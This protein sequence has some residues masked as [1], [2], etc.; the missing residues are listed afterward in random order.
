MSNICAVVIRRL[1]C[2]CRVFLS[3]VAVCF[4]R[5]SGHSFI[6]HTS[7][8]ITKGTEAPPWQCPKTI[9]HARFHAGRASILPAFGAMC[10]SCFFS[11]FRTVGK[12]K[13][14]LDPFFFSRISR[15]P[16]F[17]ITSKIILWPLALFEPK[18][19]PWSTSYVGQWM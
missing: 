14:P 12:K 5:K 15:P 1:E 9:I 6:L 11:P 2:W 13:G 8:E 7:G 4:F 16:S 10:L 17:H 3:L 18:G 19:S